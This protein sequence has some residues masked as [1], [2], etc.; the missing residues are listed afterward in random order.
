MKFFKKKAPKAPVV[1]PKPKKEERAT[2]FHPQMT[3]PSLMAGFDASIRRRA[4]EFVVE[5]VNIGGNIL[6]IA[7]DGKLSQSARNALAQAYEPN[8]AGQEIIYTYFARQSFIGFQNC[9]ILSQ[10]WLINKACM[11]PAVDAAAI[12]YDITLNDDETTDEDNRILDELKAKATFTQ[13][14][15]IIG[16]CR[17]FAEKKRRFGQALCLPVVDDVDYSLP[18]NIDAVGHHTYKGMVNIEPQWITPVLDGRASNDPT[19]RRFYKPTYFRLPDGQIVHHSWVQFATYGNIPD[20]LKPTYYFG[21]Y[22]LPQLLYEQVYAAEKT[23]KE[24][25]MLAQSKRLNYMEGNLNAYITNADKMDKEIRLMSWLRN[26]WGWMLVGRDQKLG[27]LDTSLTDVDSVTMLSYQ[28]VAAIAGMPSARLLET[29]PKGWQSSGSYEDENYKKLLLSIQ[30]QDFVPILN[31]HYRLLTKSEY[32]RSYEYNCV[33]TPIDTPSAKEL[34]EIN[35]INSRTNAAYISAGVVSAEEVRNALRQDENSGFN[36]L[37]EEMEAEEDLSGL[38]GEE[39]EQPEEPKDEPALDA[40]QETDHPRDKDGRF[41]SSGSNSTGSKKTV[42]KLSK[43]EY[44]KITHELNTN[45]TKEEINKGY[46]ERYIG[47]RKYY[48]FINGFNDYKIL[49]WEKIK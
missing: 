8:I 2:P 10:N 33:F 43:K 45:L 15:D 32:G 34:A 42:V 39:E 3:R 13:N 9:A 36:A 28:I 37:S 29:S 24:A 46:T 47:N 25:P 19:C 22:P 38:F 6:N 16:I 48:I 11:Q 4:D 49:D 27:Q 1:M 21:G 40:W 14:Y 23:A 35:E 17:E 41:S 44:G 12:A 7:T 31:R 18:F 20:I 5:Q 30:E 26:N